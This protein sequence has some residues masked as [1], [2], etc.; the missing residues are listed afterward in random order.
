MFVGGQTP[1]EFV[2]DNE[3]DLF[4]TQYGPVAGHVEVKGHRPNGSARLC[5]HA[6]E[7]PIRCHL[8]GWDWVAQMSWYPTLFQLGAGTPVIAARRGDI[9]TLAF[10][11]VGAVDGCGH[12]PMKLE[13]RNKFYY[14]LFPLCFWDDE[15]RGLPHEKALIGVWPD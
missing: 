14:K 1:I 13:E 2:F 3:N 15:P 7:P 10:D 4:T 11:V 5:C 12:V 6:I 9:V 8:F